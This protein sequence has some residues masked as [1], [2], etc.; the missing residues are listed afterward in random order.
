MEKHIYKWT[1]YTNRCSKYHPKTFYDRIIK[2][3][4]GRVFDN[5]WFLSS[6]SR[7]WFIEERT[8]FTVLWLFATVL[9]RN[10]YELDWVWRHSILCLQGIFVSIVGIISKQ[11]LDDDVFGGPTNR[12]T[13]ST[14]QTK[15]K[16]LI[17][18]VYDLSV[19]IMCS[20]FIVWWGQNKWSNVSI[21]TVLTEHFM[22]YY[23]Y[24]CIYV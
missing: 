23:Y 10:Y 16:R 2:L 11:A 12:P 19:Y 15:T 20:M 14:D 8:A 24:D 21:Y 5:K 22:N 6:P 7:H 1:G 13:D 3:Y 18:I 9:D 17:N 4:D